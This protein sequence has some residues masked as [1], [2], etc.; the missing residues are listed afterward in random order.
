MA[1]CT[2]YY[3][4]YGGKTRRR[5]CRPGLGLRR[6]MARMVDHVCLDFQHSQYSSLKVET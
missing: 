6:H 1:L 2:V 4:H 3:S 5:H